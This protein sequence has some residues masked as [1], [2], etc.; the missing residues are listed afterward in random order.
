[1]AKKNI[2][3]IT[4]ER[5]LSGTLNMEN[6]EDEGVILLETEDGEINLVDQLDAMNGIDIEIKLKKVKETP[7]ILP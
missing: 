4:E 5:I 2:R 6:Y 3:I 7:I 1:M